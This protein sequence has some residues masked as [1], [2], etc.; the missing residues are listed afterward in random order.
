MIGAILAVYLLFAAAVYL[1]RGIYFTPDL[2]DSWAIFLLLGAIVI[3]RWKSFLWDWVPL[4]ALL[5]GYEML[6]G[7][8]GSSV[9][10]G[11]ILAGQPSMVHLHG[12][13]RA[14]RW[15]FFGHVPTVWLQEKLYQEGV[16][17]WYDLLASLVYS[18]HFALPLIFGFVLWIRSRNEFRRFSITLL[19]MT[20]G[21]FVIYLL[22]PT[23]PPWLANHWGD[24]PGVHDPFN[25]ALEAIT[26][27]RFS[28]FQSMTIFTKASPDPVAAFPSLH[29]AYPW[30][31][32]LFLVRTFAGE[33]ICT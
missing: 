20:Y 22:Y 23:A 33:A 27:S 17:H 7:F 26:P 10:K 13:I 14:D 4:I 16:V 30:L 12:L 5:F 25:S 28:H 1:W 11:D 9:I 15:L 8:I 29:A 31:I 21:T 19:I 2:P 32:M 18:L 3:G 6:R 24:L